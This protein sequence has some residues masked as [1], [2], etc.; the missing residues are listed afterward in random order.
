[1]YD[2]AHGFEDSIEKITHSLCTLE[3]ENHRPLYN[4][5]IE[6]VNEGR[7]DDKKIWHP[8]Q[9]EFARLNITHVMMSKRKLRTLVEEKIVS[10]LG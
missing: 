7:P 3:F 2:W 4:W 10:G 1:M 8:Q 9:I 6:A 5:F